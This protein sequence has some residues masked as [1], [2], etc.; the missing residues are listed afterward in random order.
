[1]TSCF[2]ELARPHRKVYGLPSEYR[3]SATLDALDDSIGKNINNIWIDADGVSLIIEHESGI[4]NISD[5][6][7]QCCESRYMETDDNLKDFI[8]AIIINFEYK[9]GGFIDPVND[10]VLEVAFFDIKT[11]SGIFQIKN[12]NENN[13]YYCGF[14][15]SARLIKR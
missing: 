7:Q 5:N 14:D 10:T 15:L 8:G 12:Y 13:G 3:N 1:M 9:D 2:I 6:G 11:T 4:L